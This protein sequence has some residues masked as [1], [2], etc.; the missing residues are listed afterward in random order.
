MTGSLQNPEIETEAS[1]ETQFE[2]LI[3]RSAE[4]G[5]LKDF[6]RKVFAKFRTLKIPGSENESW[7][8]IPLSNFHPE[9]FTAVAGLDSVSW[10]TSDGIK[11]QKADVWNVPNSVKLLKS[12]SLSGK[13][14]EFFLETLESIFQKQNE[15]WFALYS[16]SNFTHGIYLEIGSDV[17]RNNFV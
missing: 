6:R 2:N 11:L 3:S 14:L 15:E 5:A 4:S 1:L 10:K 12:E 8:K 13:E 16:L 7:R 9:E 17:V